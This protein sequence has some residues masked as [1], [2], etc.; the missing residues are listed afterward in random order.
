[1]VILLWLIFCVIVGSVAK[2]KGRSFLAFALLSVVISPIGGLIV[3]LLMGNK[4]PEQVNSYSA[5]VPDSQKLPDTNIQ[6]EVLDADNAVSFC[7][8]CGAMLAPDAK[9]CPKCGNQIRA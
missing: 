5:S 3:L 9:F 6:S 1:M 2:N 7:P 4:V 8:N